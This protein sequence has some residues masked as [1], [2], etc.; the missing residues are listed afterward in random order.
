M[1][2]DEVVPEREAWVKSPVRTRLQER[3]LELRRESMKARIDARR[4]DSD[5]ES[6]V[7]KMKRGSQ[8]V[9]VFPFLLIY[10]LIFQ[11]LDHLLN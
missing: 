6:S 8:M 11:V 10:C 3:R 1:V 7:Q 9:K 4:N 5:R 2:D